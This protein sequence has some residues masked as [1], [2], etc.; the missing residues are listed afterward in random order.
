[1]DHHQIEQLVSQSG[2]YEGWILVVP[3][4]LGPKAAFAVG[5]QAAH[6][7]LNSLRA[8]VASGDITGVNKDAEIVLWGYSGGSQPTVW[9]AA[10]FDQ[11]APE[12][13]IIGAAAGGILV[14][15]THISNITMDGIFA[16]LIIN[17]ING[18]A[19]E[20]E[21]LTPFIKENFYEGIQDKFFKVKTQCL[22]STV[23][24]TI[25]T[26]WDDLT[27]LGYKVLDAPIV[28][29]Y[30]GINNLLNLNST[31]SVPL[32]FYNSQGD[33]IIPAVDADQLY[34]KWCSEGAIIEYHQDE[35][36][37]HLTQVLAGSAIAFNWLKRRFS[38]ATLENKCKKTIT[39]S[40]I[41]DIEGFGSFAKIIGDAI[42]TFKEQEIGP[43]SPSSSSPLISNASIS[44][45][46]TLTSTNSGVSLTSTCSRLLGLLFDLFF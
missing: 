28:K 42:S 10:L 26:T 34:D 16:G 27:P 18:L 41:F 7:T 31:P 43:K 29:K 40:N 8:V 13:N 4:Y 23:F 33:E 39:F 30:T 1:M 11:Y 32:F 15:P 44:T 6:A 19:N 45:S 21:D 35:T 5:L 9:A 22:A 14:S 25:F 2:L 38:G 46:V 24:E 3:D 37:K 20:Y 12:L 36:G 17:A